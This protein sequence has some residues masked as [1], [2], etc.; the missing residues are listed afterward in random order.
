SRLAENRHGVVVVLILQIGECFL[1]HLFA[2]FALEELFQESA[3]AQIGELPHERDVG[4]QLLPMPSEKQPAR[5]AIHIIDSRSAQDVPSSVVDEVAS[6]N[7]GIVAV[8][9]E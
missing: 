2:E 8:A 6:N 9:A 5:V 1:V 4:R 7:R 3:V